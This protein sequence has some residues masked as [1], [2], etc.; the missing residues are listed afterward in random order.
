MKDLENGSW[1]LLPPLKRAFLFK[2]AIKEENFTVTEIARK[3]KKSV[4]FVSNTLRLLNLPEIIKD[5]LISKTISEGHA[6]A[7]GTIK[8]E[9]TMVQVYKKILI[10]EASVRQAEKLSRDSLKKKW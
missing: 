4:P 7:L 10:E 3:I 1:R 8:E 9:K 5:G 2:R 6:R